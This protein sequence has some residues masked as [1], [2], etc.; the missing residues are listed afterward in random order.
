MSLPVR[1]SGEAWS[2]L[3]ESELE[4]PDGSSR[5]PFRSHFEDC[6]CNLLILPFGRISK[7]E[8]VRKDFEIEKGI[9]ADLRDCR[10]NLLILPFGRISKSG[11]VHK[12]FEAEKGLVPTFEIADASFSS[13]LSVG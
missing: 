7:S 13:S 10:C 2:F 4:E 5:T 9:G 1:I 11:E 12:D 6:R 3:L 8:E